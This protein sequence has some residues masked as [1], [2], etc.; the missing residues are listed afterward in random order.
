M[1]KRVISRAIIIQDNKVLLM[2]RRK[3]K[4][5]VKKEYY[6]VPGGGQDENETLEQTVARELKEELNVDIKILGFLGTIELDDTISNYYQCEIT[7]GTPQLGGE[8]LDGMTEE[9]YYEPRWIELSNIDNLDLTA[10]DLVHKA[11]QLKLK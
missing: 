7:K 3:I 9:N 2:F 11:M 6:V 1:V 8:E 5:G 4:D 10:K